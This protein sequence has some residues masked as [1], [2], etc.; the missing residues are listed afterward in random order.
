MPPLRALFPMLVCLTEFDVVVF[1]A[2]YYILFCYGFLLSFRRMMLSNERQEEGRY[3]E[4][5]RRWR[6]TE[7][8]GQKNNSN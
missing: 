6:G 7:R 2:P 5:E 8:S 3:R 4:R 1:A